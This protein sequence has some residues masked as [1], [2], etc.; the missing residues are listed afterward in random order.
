MCVCVCVCVCVCEAKET[1]L[2]DLE[3]V[4]GDL[5]GTRAGAG[6]GRDAEMQV[7]ELW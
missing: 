3:S 2:A 5:E 7:S 4:H 1:A 6:S